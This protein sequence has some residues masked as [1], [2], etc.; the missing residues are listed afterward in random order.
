MDITILFRYIAK[1]VIVST[2]LVFL[3]ILAL[4]F[5]ISLVTELRDTGV[6]DYGFTQ[7]IEHVILMLP[8]VLYQF[9]PMLMLLGGVLGLGVLASN[10][11]LIVMRTSGLSIRS[12]V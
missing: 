1:S 6:G 7:A 10:Q 4:S 3:V 8:H 12:I 2:A 11:E 9:F 5:I